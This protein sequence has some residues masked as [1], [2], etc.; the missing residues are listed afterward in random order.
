MSISPAGVGSVTKNPD[1]SG[2][3]GYGVSVEL[4]AQ[5]TGNYVFNTWS[6]AYSGSQNPYSLLMDN[7]KTITANF[8][9][10]TV[11]APTP[12]SGSSS[13]FAG[14]TE[15]Y[16]ASGASS[17]LGHS[18]EYQFDW[19]DGTLSSWGSA[20]RSYSWSTSGTKT[21]RAKARCATH[22][23]IESGWSSGKSV[24]VSYCTLSVAVNPSGS[25][26]VTKNPD[27]TGYTYNE[28]VQLTPQANIG[29]TF[30]NWT[31]DAAGSA[32]PYSLATSG[33]KTVTA[34]F[35]AAGLNFVVET[36]P[37]A[38]PEGGTGSTRV[39]LSQA[40][41]DTVVASVSRAAGDASIT[42]QSGATLT[43]TSGNWNTWQTVTLAAAED[44]D[45]SNGSATMLIRRTSGVN[46]V[47][48]RN[49]TAT[50]NENDLTL[51]ITI[52]PSGSGSVTKNP[53]KAKYN[54]NETVQLTPQ[55][56][57]GY[58]FVNWTGDATGTTVPYP[59][60]MSGNKS[61]TANFSAPGLT[62][63][64]ETDPVA[65]PE[66]SSATTRVRL[67]QQP[68]GD[69][70]A[71]VSR[72]SGDADITVASGG[73]LTFTSGNWNTWQTVTFQAAEDNADTANGSAVIRVH[74]TS[75]VNSIPDRDFTA[76]EVD[77]DITLTV[78]ND[79]HGTTTP[80]GATI[81]EKSTWVNVSATANTGY[82]FSRWTGDTAGV[83]DV[84]TASTRINTT[85]NA[86]I[87]ATFSTV[88][89]AFVAAADS[90]P[91]GGTASMRVK[92]SGPPA[93]AVTATVTRSSGDSDISVQS[94]SPVTITQADWDTWHTVTLRAAEDNGETVNGVAVMRIL[95]TGGTSPIDPLNVN[96]TEADDDIVLTVNSGGHGTATGG[97]IVDSNNDMP[98]PIS[99]SPDAGWRFANWSGDTAGIANVNAASTTINTPVNAT[100]QAN[101]T[102]ITYTLTVG[103]SGSGQAR[104][105]GTL[106]NLPWQES[107][108]INSAVTVEAVPATY[109]QFDN[110][111]GALTGSANP[112]TVT[113]NGDKSVTANFSQPVYALTV[114]KSGNGRCRVNGTV[115]DLPWTENFT[116]GL[117]IPVEA[118]PDID[119]YFVRWTQDVPSGQETNP[120]VSILMDRAK[121][122]T[123]NYAIK[124]F[125]ITTLPGSHG[126]IT[127]VNPVVY[128]GSTQPLT[129]IPDTYY[130]V[131]AV[132]V[133]GGS[134]G[135]V[136]NYTFS[137]VT[138]AQTISA[139]FAEDLAAND[140][141]E[142]W[143]AQHGWTSDF[144]T[145]A[146]GDQDSDGLF[147]WQEYRWRTDPHNPD[148]DLDGLTD[149][150]EVNT[151]STDPANPDSDGDR[152]T[153]GRELQDGTN[154][155]QPGDG[156]LTLTGERVFSLNA[157]GG[158]CAGGAAHGLD[159]I[160]QGCPAGM[161]AGSA[162]ANFSGFQNT[163]NPRDF[164]DAPRR[165]LY[166][167][168]GPHGQVAADPWYTYLDTISIPAMP[169]TYY[170]FHSWTGDVPAGVQTTNPIALT[171]NQDRHVWAFFAENLAAHGVP[172]WWLAQH[173]W[174]NNFAAATELDPDGDALPNWGEYFAGTSP[175]IVD[176]DGDNI[177]DGRE[178]AD[179]TSPT[180]AASYRV[181]VLRDNFTCDAGGGICGSAALG[182][183]SA[184]GQGCP[185]GETRG[186]PV[187]NGSGFLYAG[188]DCEL[189]TDG[190][191]IPDSLD[192][193]KDGD[194]ISD[195]DEIVH[196]TNPYL[197]DTDGDGQDDMEEA[198]AGTSGTN[199]NDMFR[200]ADGQA[201]TNG[202]GFV[203]IWDTV[204]GRLYKVHTV[205]NL[206][207]PAWS[208]VYQTPGDGHRK[209]YTNTESVS[210]QR[211]FKIT[212]EMQ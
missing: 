199:P 63:S 66:G 197:R 187:V 21:I 85:V 83:E 22:T 143:L 122:L 209:A 2:G 137:N 8:L 10:E 101:F 184:V 195:A 149:G 129:I 78:N 176:T 93:D 168:V 4:T 124:T 117:T 59:L 190:D 108:V 39:K 24:T 9:Q 193:D 5:G 6:G 159:S 145:A 18:L 161:T 107:F 196:G 44:A 198:I 29:Y 105:N 156:I 116:A 180:N 178:V 81:V 17:T 7:N 173:G 192:T 11:S 96:A 204:T 12:V 203:L 157:G 189:D 41:A 127:P 14:K 94:G 87:T 208:N 69:I 19:G 152:V 43:F 106:R 3:Y 167:I 49:F 64:V 36:D 37:V 141:P 30:A 56:G 76:N 205:T 163:F 146:L 51:S 132:L 16:S 32:V 140:T 15:S 33:D 23:G 82:T 79:G 75:G 147:T 1:Y 211:F 121:A 175:F 138:A 123:V 55:P 191:G 133:N 13:T 166:L 115:R 42:V 151:H 177:T 139:T 61:V 65:V 125:Q 118:V 135:A 212:V 45:T 90:V 148:T 73:T 174:T 169:D 134:V 142:W 172:E 28:T 130:H 95:K 181:S 164:N 77:D 153:D 113:M 74:K 155:T 58:V 120:S 202:T 47:P 50:E 150:S 200:V 186:G 131:A 100:V 136:S 183:V 185:L 194:G 53:D 201:L 97:G 25:G 62:F 88:G 27:K 72:A 40:P 104:V 111:T 67:S 86:T 99:A 102:E 162:A 170:H 54:F 171:M 84:N 112:Q 31:G 158:Q 57:T 71:T 38:V 128:Y 91:E 98:R 207:V 144:D 114:A 60:V 52:S 68:A 26:S 92:L 46:L 126:Q 48:D 34:N 80:A 109:W 35:S 179:G 89:L 154:P 110:W 206:F 70:V 119:S 103:R 160:G 20:T 165:F 188:L 210:Q 182:G